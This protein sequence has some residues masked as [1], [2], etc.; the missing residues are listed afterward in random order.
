MWSLACLVRVASV[1]Y[2]QGFYNFVE[3][4]LA[5]SVNVIQVVLCILLEC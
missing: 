3:A 2:A 5:V 4:R 1:E